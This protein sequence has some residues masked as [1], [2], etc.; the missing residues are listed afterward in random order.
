MWPVQQ[1]ALPSYPRG[2][3]QRTR[4]ISNVLAD[5]NLFNAVTT[6]QSAREA[7][8]TMPAPLASSLRSTLPQPH[9]GSPCPG[10]PTRPP[11]AKSRRPASSHSCAL[12]PGAG[13]PEPPRAAQPRHHVPLAT[14]RSPP[15]APAPAPA[16]AAAFRAAS[17]S[18]PPPRAPRPARQPCSRTARTRAATSG[19]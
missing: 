18:P 11:P 5:S 9:C 15:P 16:P 6:I 19:S 14:Q 12:L 4:R 10:I 17:L 2:L 7:T 3:L 1:Q 8:L 13:P